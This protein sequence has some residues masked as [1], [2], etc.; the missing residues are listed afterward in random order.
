MLLNLR[1]VASETYLKY[2]AQ[3][4]NFEDIFLFLERFI[5]KHITPPIVLGVNLTP[6][7]LLGTTD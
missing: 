2:T 5:G 3:L 4:A 1:M 7:N 6:F